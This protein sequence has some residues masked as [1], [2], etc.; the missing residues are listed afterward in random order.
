MNHLVFR[1]DFVLKEPFWIWLSLNFN[2]PAQE[3][4]SMT[5]A[6]RIHVQVLLKYAERRNSKPADSTWMPQHWPSEVSQVRLRTV[7]F[8]RASLTG[9]SCEAFFEAVCGLP[10]R[11][12]RGD[13]VIFARRNSAPQDASWPRPPLTCLVP[14]TQ[15]YY[16]Q[17]RKS[18]HIL[19]TKAGSMLVYL[20]I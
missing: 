1:Y 20:K 16:L 6:R 14:E 17:P 5:F 7:Q 12:D 3:T 9:R 15:V 2:P 19:V 11:R 13:V 4:D 8:S 10:A 18:Q